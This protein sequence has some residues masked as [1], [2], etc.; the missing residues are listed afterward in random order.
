MPF[1]KH[2]GM[3]MEDVP[4]VYLHWLWTRRPLSHTKLE[5]YIHNNIPHLRLEHP[6]GIWT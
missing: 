4:A 6:D 2:K 5:N 3:P 1:G